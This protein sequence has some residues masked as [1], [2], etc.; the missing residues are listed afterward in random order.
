[1]Q[2]KYIL[3][4][5]EKSYNIKLKQYKLTCDIAISKNQIQ[6]AYSKQPSIVKLIILT[7]A[8]H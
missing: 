6:L 8:I 7:I 3:N 2:S 1:M 5:I 4:S